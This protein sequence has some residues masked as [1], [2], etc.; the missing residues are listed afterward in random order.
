MGFRRRFS[1]RAAVPKAVRRARQ[2]AAPGFEAMERR[3]LMA[4]VVSQPALIAGQPFFGQIATFAGGDVQGTI[5][6]F[7]AKIFQGDS[8]TNSVAG[9]IVAVG[10]NQY[11]VLGGLTYTNPGIY[12]L[13]VVVSGANGSAASGQATEVVKDAPQNL[14]AA[15]VQCDGRCAVLGQRR[16]VRRPE[17]V[18]LGR[19]LRGH[20]RLGRRQPPPRRARSWPA[21]P[22]SSP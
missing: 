8:A 11:E 9:T 6:N 7:S 22:G 2:G 5:S 21:R 10:T 3:S 13:T 18:G 14:V 16:L 4:V 20:R 19:Q 17:R 15:P 12:N 1:D